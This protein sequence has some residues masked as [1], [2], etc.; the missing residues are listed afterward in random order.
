MII[1]KNKDASFDYS[2]EI[3]EIDDLSPME[4]TKG[5][6]KFDKIVLNYSKEMNRFYISHY[7]LNPLD[8]FGAYWDITDSGCFSFNKEELELLI[9]E[10]ITLKKQGE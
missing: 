10:L 3:T 8:S 1:K 9:K 7:Y 6:L 2:V 4:N 5:K